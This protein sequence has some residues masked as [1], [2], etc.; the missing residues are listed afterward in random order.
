MRRL[1]LI[2]M[3]PVRVIV[4]PFRC[5]LNMKCLDCKT[6]IDEPFISWLSVDRLGGMDSKRLLL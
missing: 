2:C 6:D 3:I 1:N 5:E 4:Y